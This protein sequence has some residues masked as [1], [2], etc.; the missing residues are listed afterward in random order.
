MVDKVTALKIGSGGRLYRDAR[1]KAGQSTI[2]TPAPSVGH[3]APPIPQPWTTSAVQPESVAPMKSPRNWQQF[4]ATLLQLLGM[5]L[6]TAGVSLVFI[7]AGL[8]VAGICAVVLG[9]AV[10]LP[11]P[12]TLPRRGNGR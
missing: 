8:I 12:P 1:E 5:A 10:G 3:Q 6:V 11:G 4:Y 2:P 9:V 7:P